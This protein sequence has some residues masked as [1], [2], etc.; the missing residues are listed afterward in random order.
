MCVRFLWHHYNK[1][2][3]FKQPKPSKKLFL[4]SDNGSSTVA[5]SSFGKGFSRRS[6][7]KLP[8]KKPFLS[9][10][11]NTETI[12][13]KS[14]FSLNIY[15]AIKPLV[16]LAIFSNTIKTTC[17]DRDFSKRP[18]KKENKIFVAVCYF[19]VLSSLF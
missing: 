4:V 11:G 12:P 13:R 1:I 14:L 15:V 3:N 16:R 2:D 5:L 18:S 6:L 9:G 17:L 19:S 7:S 10:L 8:G